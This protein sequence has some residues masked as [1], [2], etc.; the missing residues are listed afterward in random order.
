MVYIEEK[1][2]KAYKNPAFG[3]NMA[4][5]RS[6]RVASGLCAEAVANSQRLGGTCHL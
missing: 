1:P 2:Y 6:M 3:V 4:V 5:S